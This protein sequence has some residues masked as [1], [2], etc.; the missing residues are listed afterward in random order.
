MDTFSARFDAQIASERTNSG[1]NPDF[2]GISQLDSPIGY[3]KTRKWYTK[4]ELNE[5][6][7]MDTFP[8]RFDAWIPSERANPGR[9]QDFRRYF[10]TGFAYRLYQIKKMVCQD[11]NQ[12]ALSHGHLSGS[13]RCSDPIRKGKS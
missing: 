3:T 12:R 5:L 6:Y 4:I 1:R 2:C 11:R 7:R 10:A 8:A 9:N 13:I